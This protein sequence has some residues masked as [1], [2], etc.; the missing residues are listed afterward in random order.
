M[1]EKKDIFETVDTLSDDAVY[2]LY[3][4]SKLQNSENDIKNGKVMTVDES[5]ERMRKKYANFNVK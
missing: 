5:K 2:T 3:L 1:N 4:R